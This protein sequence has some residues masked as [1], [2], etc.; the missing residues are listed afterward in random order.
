[1]FETIYVRILPRTS[2]TLFVEKYGGFQ[3]WIMQ[4][5]TELLYHR[6]PT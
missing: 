3:K 6:S 2:N 4:A 1:M 5:H